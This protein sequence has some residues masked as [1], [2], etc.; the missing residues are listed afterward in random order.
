MSESGLT[1][2][3]YAATAEHLYVHNIPLN[4]SPQDERN[5]RMVLKMV[6]L[7]ACVMLFYDIMLTFADEVELIWSRSGSD[8]VDI[9]KTNQIPKYRHKRKPLRPY[10]L[11]LI[12]EGVRPD[13][14]ILEPPFDGRKEG[15]KWTFAESEVRVVHRFT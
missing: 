10:K 1:P 6:S 8:A 2:E 5:L 14:D 11:N 13:S 4:C 9:K 12:G 7:S 3:Q 15:V